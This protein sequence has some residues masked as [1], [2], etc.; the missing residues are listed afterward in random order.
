ME[1]FEVVDALVRVRYVLDL[2][3]QD[4]RIALE[5]DGYEAHEYRLDRDVERDLDLERRGWITIRAT[6]ADL[7][8]PTAL[9]ARLDDAFAPG[10]RR[11]SGRSSVSSDAMLRVIAE[12]VSSATAATTLCARR[13]GHVPVR[14]TPGTKERHGG[15]DPATHRAQRRDSRGRRATRPVSRSGADAG[16][17]PDSQVGDVV[18]GSACRLGS[19]GDDAEVARRG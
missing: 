8:E 4:L 18:F 13:P 5:Y 15:Q 2:C 1:Q 19:V 12:Q 11:T 17:G 10:V 6:A 7:R 3:W 9:L 16:A 14:D